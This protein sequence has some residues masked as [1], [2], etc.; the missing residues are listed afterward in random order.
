MTT[1]IVVMFLAIGVIGGFIAGLLGV[2]G[3]ILFVPCL[4]LGFT[5][6]GLNEKL[7]MEVAVGTSLAII[8]VTSFSSAL[9]HALH[10]KLTGGQVLAMAI[11]AIPASVVG[12]KIAVLIG[13]VLLKKLF[14]VFLLF[15]SYRFFRPPHPKTI[16]PDRL[17]PVPELLLVGGC[18]GL[19]SSMLGIGGG[20]ITVSMLHLWLRQPIHRAVANSSGLIVF[21]SIAGTISW[22]WEGWNTEGLP[23]LSYGYVNLA[24][25]ALIAFTSVIFAQVGAHLAAR[26]RPEGLQKPFAVILLLVGLDMLLT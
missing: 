21:T 3:G 7:S 12:A 18:S 4:Y 6:M 20:I 17:I 22:I 23:V 8:V 11:L 26:T 19:L 14:G 5:W 13:G 15:V 10:G 9:G 24:G 16:D 25:W 2:G 1:S